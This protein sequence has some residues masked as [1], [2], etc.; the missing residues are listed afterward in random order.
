MLT[1]SNGNILIANSINFINK[2]ISITTY[3]DITH[4]NSGD[5]TY[6]KKVASTI[7]IPNG[8][9]Y[10]KFEVK[11]VNCDS[12]IISAIETIIK[13]IDSSWSDI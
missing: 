2:K 11:G 13:D 12:V 1:N 8:Y 5:T 9:T 7:V 3:N 4:Y 6:I 10:P